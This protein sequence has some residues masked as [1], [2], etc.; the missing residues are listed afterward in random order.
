M[1]V[2]STAGDLEPCTGQVVRSGKL[3]SSRSRLVLVRIIPRSPHPQWW[4]AT[5]TE[6]TSKSAGAGHQLGAGGCRGH[7]PGWFP[8][9][10]IKDSIY[11]SCHTS[12]ADRWGVRSGRAADVATPA[13]CCY[14]TLAG[15]FRRADPFTQVTKPS[16]AL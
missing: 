11:Q 6:A 1:N 13:A 14:E 15:S 16:E 12:A 7:P 4:V 5:E 2:A 10:L 9:R 3:S 8:D